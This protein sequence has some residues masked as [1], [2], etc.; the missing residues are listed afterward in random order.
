MTTKHPRPESYGLFN[1]AGKIRLHTPIAL[2]TRIVR[3]I[4][5]ARVVGVEIEH[6]GSGRRELVD[7]DCV[8]FTG[9][10]IADHELARSAGIELAPGTR[11]PLVD[12]ALRTSQPGLFAA[13]NL[14][15]PVDTADVAARDGLHVAEQVLTWIR[16]DRPE[17]DSVRLI[18][19]RPL[20]W[21]APGLLRG[22][23]PAPPRGRLLLWTDELVRVPRVL[24]RQDGREIAR[25]TLPWP[26]SPGRMFRVPAQ[27]LSNVNYSGG[28][29]TVG[30]TTRV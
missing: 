10:W 24:V 18:V 9:D 25:R 27:L 22:G 2:R 29:V 30:L 23:D 26:A 12:T 21:I 15:H 17:A 1:I 28:A 14:L 19:E 8:I 3:I 16:G 7:C 5:K 11:A 4:G 6:L 13:G 20:R